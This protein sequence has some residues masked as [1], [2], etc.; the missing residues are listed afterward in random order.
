MNDRAGSVKIDLLIP[1]TLQ[2]SVDFYVRAM[3][4]CTR[5]RGATEK[6]PSESDC[7]ADARSTIGFSP[8]TPIRDKEVLHFRRLMSIRAVHLTQNTPARLLRLAAILL[9]IAT[10]LPAR[11]KVD[12]SQLYERLYCVLP[13]NAGK[14]TWAEPK[15]PMSAPSPAQMS[16]TSRTGI[17][18]YTHVLS[19]DGQS[20]LEIGRAHV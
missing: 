8:R 9:A 14:G 19:D 16:P 17:I 13:M 6:Q 18:G 4:I 3:V 10:C 1:N 20:A 5:S 11:H 7:G 12:T 2:K 15:R